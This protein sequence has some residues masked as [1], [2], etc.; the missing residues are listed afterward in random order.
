MIKLSYSTLGS[1]NYDLD[2]VIAAA[3]ESGYTGVELRFLRGTVGLASLDEFAPEGIART[4]EN[5]ESAGLEVACVDTSVRFTSPDP[6]ERDRQLESARTYLRIASELRAPYIRVFGGPIPTDQ[7]AAET[8]KLIADG[9][10]RAATAAEEFDVT[11]L[12]E[13]HDTFSTGA[14]VAELLSNGMPDRFAIL[15]DFLHSYRSGED[16]TETYRI[17]GD[18]VRHV[19]LKDSAEFSPTGFDLKLMGQGRLPVREFVA[20]LTKVGY[21]GYVSFEWEKAWHPEIEEPEVA[22]PQ[23]ADYMTRL[24]AELAGA[25]A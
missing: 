17:L 21:D 2:Q 22:L 8:T 25:G 16:F 24:L 14:Q 11:V 4:R 10:E 15:W 5:L 13:T 23:Y 19:H 6:D 12:L 9:L 1:P 20:F 3:T 7:D 18:K